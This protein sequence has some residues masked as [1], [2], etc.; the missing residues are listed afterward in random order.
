MDGV[1]VRRL[2]NAQTG[3]QQLVVEALTSYV[4][5][6]EADA[7]WLERFIAGRVPASEAGCWLVAAHAMQNRAVGAVEGWLDRPDVPEH[8]RSHLVELLT[9]LLASGSGAALTE[10]RFRVLVDD[11][12]GRPVGVHEL[13][14]PMAFI[15][16]VLSLTS[17][18]AGDASASVILGE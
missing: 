17:N 16:E 5:C 12:L 14:V 1:V 8:V 3:L 10:D 13:T 4:S 2:V 6:E 11:A 15:L 18:C 9:R 7:A